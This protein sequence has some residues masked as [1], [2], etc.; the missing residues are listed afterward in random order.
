MRQLVTGYTEECPPGLLSLFVEC[1][2]DPSRDLRDLL[3][4]SCDKFLDSYS[5]DEREFAKSR[6]QIS[7]KL[8][9]KIM[10]SILSEEHQ[11]IGKKSFLS[12]VVQKRIVPL[13][14]L[15]AAIEI[16]L[17]SYS[18]QKMFPE[19]LQIL[20]IHPYEFYK[21]IE[22]ILRAEL[23]SGMSLPR[24]I[25]KYLSTIEERVLEELS[26][27]DES[28][29]W[30]SLDGQKAP[31]CA[32]VISQSH[33]ENPL[34]PTRPVQ[35]SLSERFGSPI[36]GSVKRKLFGEVKVVNQAVNRTTTPPPPTQQEDSEMETDEM[37]L[38]DNRSS[39][40]N[41]LDL[42]FRKIYH[43]ASR[44]IQHLAEKLH[45][46][47]NIVQTIFTLFEQCLIDHNSM[48]RGRHID[49][50]HIKTLIS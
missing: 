34:S 11:R 22:L 4:A 15:A 7:R 2:N 8:F 27:Q 5:A 39:K 17:W 32:D 29:L 30:S 48:L 1:E 26:W 41:S 19:V 31:K 33:C 44:R 18:S 23:G 28:P 35:T 3:N 20:D 16:T 50:V 43:L 12:D 24:E 49:Q 14:C 40:K 45:L 38:R 37:R 36:K 13:S 42:F 9:W 21:V 6:L 47:K 25:V 10:E 46:S